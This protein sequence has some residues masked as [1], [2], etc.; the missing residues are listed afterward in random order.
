MFH[1]GFLSCLRFAPDSDNLSP[2]QPMLNLKLGQPVPTA[3]A[4][5]INYGRSWSVLKSSGLVQSVIEG[6]PVTLLNLSECHSVRITNPRSMREGAEFSIRFFTEEGVFVLRADMPTDHW[7]WVTGVER[8]LRDMKRE[9]IISGNKCRESAYI[10]LKRLIL[11]HK[12]GVSGSQLGQCCVDNDIIHS[13]YIEPDSRDQPDGCEEEKLLEAVPPLP[14]RTREHSVP[15]LPPRDPPPSLPPKRSNSLQ[16]GIRFTRA[17]SISSMSSNGSLNLDLD[18]YILM[19]SPRHTTIGSSSYSIP[20]PISEGE[21]YLAMKPFPPASSPTPT[22]TLPPPPPPLSPFPRHRTP[23]NHP[24]V[25]RVLL[26]CPSPPSSIMGSPRPAKR[27]ALLRTTSESSNITDSLRDYSGPDQSP[28]IPPHRNSSPL[29]PRRSSTLSRTANLHRDKITYGYPLS[30]SSPSPLIHRSNSALIPPDQSSGYQ[31]SSEETSS[32]D[33][34]TVNET[35]HSG[36]KLYNPAGSSSSVSSELFDSSVSSSASCSAEDLSQ[37]RQS[38][39]MLPHNLSNTVSLQALP[40]GWEKGYCQ[41]N[42]R[43]FFFNSSSGIST[44][45]YSEVLEMSQ[46][47]CITH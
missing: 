32:S 1:A 13:L 39:V 47:V 28:P 4:S 38:L 21:D 25:Q 18:E 24:P 19:Q 3:S 2:L 43:Y 6:R 12:S 7:E 16:R 29:P 30:S 8:V 14:P 44:W 27:S 37:V 11:L 36:G 20:S 34:L 9:H 26:G 15:P 5:P 17:P 23:T 40:A 35:K 41:N 33:G 45:E 31:S 42:R 10:A 46:Q 22:P